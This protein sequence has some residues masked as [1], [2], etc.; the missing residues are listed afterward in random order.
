LNWTLLRRAAHE[1]SVFDRGLGKTFDAAM[2]EYMQVSGFQRL[3]E[4]AGDREGLAGRAGGA[5]RT[6]I[7]CTE[8]SLIDAGLKCRELATI[9]DQRLRHDDDCRTRGRAVPS[10]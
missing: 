6:K 10:R 3:E 2:P 8:F 5:G 4:H 9:V 1:V 7:P